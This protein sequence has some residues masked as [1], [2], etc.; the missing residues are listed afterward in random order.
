MSKERTL[1]QVLNSPANVFEEIASRAMKA[2]ERQ[3][4]GQRVLFD[5]RGRPAAPG[6]EEPPR[7]DRRLKFPPDEPEHDPAPNSPEDVGYLPPDRRVDRPQPSSGE[8]G[9]LTEGPSSAHARRLTEMALGVD[10]AVPGADQTVEFGLVDGVPVQVTPQA[11]LPENN[12][13]TGWRYLAKVDKAP[14]YGV[15]EVSHQVLDVI[16]YAPGDSPGQVKPVS[17]LWTPAGEIAGLSNGHRC[18]GAPAKGLL[19][20]DDAGL[21]L[22]RGKLPE[23]PRSPLE[24]SYLHGRVSVSPWS[25]IRW[26]AV[27]VGLEELCRAT[28]WANRLSTIEK[29]GAVPVLGVMPG[30]HDG[31]A[32]VKRPKG[33]GLLANDKVLLAWLE[34][35]MWGT[36]VESGGW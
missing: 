34:D 1:D 4:P 10:P 17:R 8:G 21:A 18:A 31:L 16:R 25:D 32:R 24:G 22:L 19:L 28:Y 11:E 27:V 12:G 14:L 36:K 23:E 9:R 15:D 13:T 33:S 3:R 2:K 6:T 20:A 30:D 35:E 5:T 7:E 26:I 29:L